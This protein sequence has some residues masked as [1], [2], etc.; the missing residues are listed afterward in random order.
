M[1]ETK[2]PQL[3]IV[4]TRFLNPET[5]ETL[6]G[7]LYAVAGIRRLI[8]N[9][10][11]LPETVPYG[12]ARGEINDNTNRRIIKVC[13]EDYLLHVQVGAILIEME[14]AS[15]IPHVKAACDEVFADKFPYG[16]TEGIYMRSN[17]TTTDYAKY[18]IVDDERILGMSDPKSKQRPI[19]L[20]GIK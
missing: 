17:M 13:G 6:L 7:K 4:P 1:T 18:G 14:D 15:V 9:G 10:P 11:N 12:P 19:I 20:Q 5:T 2:Y 16:I 3:R 8:L